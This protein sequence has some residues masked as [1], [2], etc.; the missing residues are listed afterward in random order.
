M[1]EDFDNFFKLDEGRIF[2][3]SDDKMAD[4]IISFL[5]THDIG[6]IKRISGIPEPYFEFSYT[7]NLVIDSDDPFGED[8]IGEKINVKI[9]FEENISKLKVNEIIL[10]VSKYKIKKILSFFPNYCYSI[11]NFNDVIY[12]LEN[13]IMKASQI[14][15][16]YP[17]ILLGFRYVTDGQISDIISKISNGIRIGEREIYTHDYIAEGIFSRTKKRFSKLNDA[18]I[19]KK[20]SEKL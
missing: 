7:K 6:D 16:I 11:F 3:R 12:N 14:I 13:Q 18:E 10:N 5:S 8:S 4:Q 2:K 1:I 19:K 15:P 20:L 17:D 9:G